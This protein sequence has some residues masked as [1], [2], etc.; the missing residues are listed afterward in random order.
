MVAINHRSNRS[1]RG[2]NRPPS[3][4]S[5]ASCQ[6][7]TTTLFE[8]VDA[9]AQRSSCAGPSANT[10][11]FRT[12]LG[13]GGQL[14]GGSNPQGAA[15]QDSP[16]PSAKKPSNVGGSGIE[17]PHAWHRWLQLWRVAE[18]GAHPGGIGR[19]SSE[20]MKRI[21]GGLIHGFGPW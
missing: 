6:R 11:T 18:V 9:N 14:R 17:I 2:S 13:G 1:C 20:W 5:S 16:I 8:P 7:P 19:S 3:C 4:P 10:M 21:G 12:P 15:K